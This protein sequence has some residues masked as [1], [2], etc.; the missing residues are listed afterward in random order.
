MV[1]IVIGAKFMTEDV[2]KACASFPVQFFPIWVLFF[3]FDENCFISNMQKSDN[4]SKNGPSEIA[5]RMQE[6]NNQLPNPELGELEKR[7]PDVLSFSDCTTP[8]QQDRKE[9]KNQ[10]K[11]PKQKF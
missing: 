10:C 7:R 6:G 1:D 8:Q 5:I 9:Q 2:Q 4:I 3:Q 11:A